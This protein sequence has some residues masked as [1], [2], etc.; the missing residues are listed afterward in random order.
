M[1]KYVH[2]RKPHWPTSRLI[3]ALKV[4]DREEGE[5][6]VDMTYFKYV[7]L[8][9]LS[10]HSIGYLLPV[11]RIVYSKKSLDIFI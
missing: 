7:K 2:V 9:Y 10:C 11:F 5:T 3:A 4:I 8:V 1:Y 6:S